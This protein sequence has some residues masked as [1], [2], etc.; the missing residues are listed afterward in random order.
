MIDHTPREFPLLE[1]QKAVL[2]IRQDFSGT[3][4]LFQ[5]APEKM[6]GADL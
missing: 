1:F 4:Y 2:E 5:G 3:T 6:H